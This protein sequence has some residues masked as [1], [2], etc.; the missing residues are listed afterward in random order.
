M[1]E[2]DPDL[3]LVESAKFRST[4]ATIRQPMLLGRVYPKGRIGNDWIHTKKSA[5]FL[6][7]NLEPHSKHLWMCARVAVT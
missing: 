7:R 1:Y 3:G 6:T 4:F 2:I 5:I